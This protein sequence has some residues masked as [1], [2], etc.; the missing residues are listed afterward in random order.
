MADMEKN[1]Y[2]AKI[3]GLRLRMN[4][5]Q[6]RIMREKTPVII[7][8]E[9]W[10]AAGKGS[11][12]ADLIYSMDPRGYKVHNLSPELE[13]DCLF[14]DAAKYMT[15]LPKYGEIAIFNRSWY[16]PLIQSLLS[17]GSA[18]AA[19]SEIRAI[20]SACVRDGAVVIKLFLQISKGE[21]RRRLEKLSAD[22]LTE[23]RVSKRELRQ[24]ANYKKYLAAYDA[25]IQYTD[26]PF[27]PWD[28]IN[29]RQKRN[30]TVSIYMAVIR[31]L[32]AYFSSKQQD[33][34]PEEIYT[35]DAMLEP[36]ASVS[37]IDPGAVAGDAEYGKRLKKLQK[38]AGR[39]HQLLYQ[40]RVPV[41]I[42]YEGWDAAGK[43]GNIRRLTRELDPRGYEVHP[44]S[45]PD[46]TEKAHHYLWR[47]CN[48]LPKAGHIAIFDRTWYGR[49]M[50]ERI[51]GFCEPKRWK[52]AYGE[53]NEFERG[54]VDWGAVVLK[55]FVNID[56][57]EQLRRFEARRDTPEKQWKLTE[58]DWR[59]REKW[60][61]YVQAIDDMLRYTNTDYAPWHILQS[62]DKRY[63][64]LQAL[65]L[66]IAAVEVRLTKEM[67]I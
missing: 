40:Y 28:V 53:I 52:A 36:I 51:E 6:Q 38:R 14:S 12:I 1:E 45:A 29:A 44:I 67:E 34:F 48:R 19:F 25:M 31:R 39:L 54:L 41:I 30:A 26:F 46:A 56:S 15:R 58:E 65:E 47:F 24:N 32:E 20:E 66:F 4:E 64:R 11:R 57:D 16:R 33:A 21:Q 10:G 35:G 50:V 17:G 27:A 55:F 18:T 3:S 8:F 62:N 61:Q 49:V 42:C 5:L 7:L 23:W 9:G 63:A 43:G 2:T 13:D 60:P 22:P 59:N 37:A